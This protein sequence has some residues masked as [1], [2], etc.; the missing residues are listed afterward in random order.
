[1]SK[2]R[3]NAGYEVVL[4]GWG[5]F[6]PSPNPGEKIFKKSEDTPPLK[7]LFATLGI[8]IGSNRCVFINPRTLGTGTVQQVLPSRWPTRQP[9]AI[10]VIDDG[11]Q[12]FLDGL[13]ALKKKYPAIGKATL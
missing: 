6:E 8:G 11:S 7:E 2:R 4:V 9:I 5:E 10:A 3:K 12:A 1:M 13:T